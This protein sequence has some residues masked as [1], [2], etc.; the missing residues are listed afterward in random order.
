M[1]EQ[2]SRKGLLH[3]FIVYTVWSS[4]YLAIRIAVDPANGFPPFLMGASRMVVAALILLGLAHL[5]GKTIRPSLAEALSLAVSGSLLWVVGNGLVLW[6]ELYADSGFSCL[7]VSST[8]IW[9]TILELI[10]YKRSLTL[11]LAGSL[12]MGFLGVL[13]LSLPSLSGG[14]PSDIL[15]IVAL[16]LST[17][18]WSVGSVFQSRHPVQLSPQ[19]TSGYQHL[20]AAVGFL[21]ISVCCG[22][23]VPHPTAQAW[24]AWGYLVIFGSVLAFT[25]YIYVLKLLPISIAMT[26]AY[27][28][29]VLALFLGWWLLG[30]SITLRTILGACLV[31]LGVVG[32][33]R[34]KQQPVAP[35]PVESTQ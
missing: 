28:N 8:P 27:V 34:A 23:A 32:I 35:R 16:M 3:L 21:A 7:M 5:Q 25:S 1:N 4:T 20:F 31:I 12:V 30:E 24:V 2:L 10:I 11:L 6:A 18:G 17:V 13:V 14:N 29:P 22:E 9:A 19:A 15:A 26:Y 33:F